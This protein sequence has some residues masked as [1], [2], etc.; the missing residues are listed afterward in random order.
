MMICHTN[1][2][3]TSSAWNFYYLSFHGKKY[4]T[5][6]CDGKSNQSVQSYQY[7]I[8]IYLVSQETYRLL[9]RIRKTIGCT[10]WSESSLTRHCLFHM[11]RIK[12]IFLYAASPN[13]MRTKG[14]F[15]KWA[16]V[17]IIQDFFQKLSEI[18]KEK[19]IAVVCHNFISRGQNIEPMQRDFFRY[20][21]TAFVC[22]FCRKSKRISWL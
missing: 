10:N 15:R 6:L 19:N 9:I 4:L 2:H 7:S 8:L 16:A 14:Q 17:L 11:A 18:S 22:I 21:V 13:N 3:Q 5:D 20:L 12:N 1:C